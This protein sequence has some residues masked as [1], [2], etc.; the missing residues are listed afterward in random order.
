MRH[1]QKYEFG[2][3]SPRLG[4]KLEVTSAKP[5]FRPSLFSGSGRMIVAF[6]IKWTTTSKHGSNVNFSQHKYPDALTAVPRRGN[7]IRSGEQRIVPRAIEI[8]CGLWDD[9]PTESFYLRQFSDGLRIRT[10]PRVFK[11][12]S[13]P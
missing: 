10:M 5:I 3:E 13:M 1:W 6:T 2:Q 12:K 7:E 4:W 9:E 8:S 11:L